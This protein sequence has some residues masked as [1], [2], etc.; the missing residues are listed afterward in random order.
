MLSTATVPRRS[1]ANL[2]GRWPH[3]SANSQPRRWQ[4]KLVHPCTRLRHPFIPPRTPSGSHDGHLT[5]DYPRPSN[6]H[7]FRTAP[8]HHAGPR[9]PPSRLIRRLP[10]ERAALSGDGQASDNPLRFQPF[11]PSPRYVELRPAS[12]IRPAASASETGRC[13]GRLGDI[14]SKAASRVRAT[15]NANLPIRARWYSVR[16]MWPSRQP[17]G[18]SHS[19]S[20]PHGGATRSAHH[21]P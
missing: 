16:R 20:V 2:L 1:A 17:N 21:N 9:F 7:S 6:P 14:G 13:R 4:S 19:A 3:S 12:D 15:P 5:A 10:S 18:S 11:P 8:L